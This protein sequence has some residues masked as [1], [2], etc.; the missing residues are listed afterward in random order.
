MDMIKVRNNEFFGIRIHDFHDNSNPSHH[1]FNHHFPIQGNGLHTRFLILIEV[2]TEQIAFLK[3]I[4]VQIFRNLLFTLR[5][6]FLST[7]D[8]QLYDILFPKI[9]YNHIGSLLITSLCFNVVVAC[10]INNRAKIQ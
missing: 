10:T 9:V 5:V 7:P 3:V 2:E 1:R 8:F 4:I 6:V